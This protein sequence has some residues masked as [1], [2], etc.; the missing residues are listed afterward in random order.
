MVIK[1]VWYCNKNRQKDKW[2]KLKS[3]E[4]AGSIIG[5]RLMIGRAF[6]ISERKDELIM[7]KLCGYL[8]LIMED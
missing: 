2:T 3:C 4:R 1:T 5:N 8:S 6:H 7:V